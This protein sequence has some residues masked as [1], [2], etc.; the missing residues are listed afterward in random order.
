MAVYVVMRS[1]SAPEPEDRL[2]LNEEIL[3]KERLG[4]GVIGQRRP[5]RKG[6]RRTI[7]AEWP[8]VHVNLLDRKGQISGVD[9]DSDALERSEVLEPGGLGDDVQKV[10]CGV[11]VRAEGSA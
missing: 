11:G 1:R 3:D 8:C 2:A 4:Q 7:G 6:V 5:V 10:L 9:V